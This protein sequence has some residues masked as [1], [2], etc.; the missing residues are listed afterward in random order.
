MKKT[1]VC[2]KCMTEKPFTKFYKHPQMADGYLGKCKECTKYDVKS[3]YVENILDIDYVEKER[4][5]CRQK[6]KRLDY[7]DKYKMS[8]PETKCVSKRLKSAG[9][10]LTG[11]EIHHWNY[12]KLYDVFLLNP[13]AHK[14]VHK[15]IDFDENSKMFSRGGLLI[16][17][18]EKH[19]HLI[20]SI[21]SENN[22]DYEIKTYT[23][24]E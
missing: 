8:H 1:K 24:E 4:E 11:V 6:Y 16:D 15:Y 13:K 18:N 7:K 20:K 2:F 14:L 17:S 19:L 5:R 9:V 3:K 12:N 22:V 10:D 23:K 21:F